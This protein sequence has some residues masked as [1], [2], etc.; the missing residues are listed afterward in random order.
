MKKMILILLSFNCSFAAF[1]Q[2]DCTQTTR[3]E[4]RELYCELQRGPNF[5]AEVAA[6]KDYCK[7]ESAIYKRVAD[8][9]SQKAD[10]L[11]RMG[12]DALNLRLLS[13]QYAVTS[14]RA[15]QATSSISLLELKDSMSSFSGEGACN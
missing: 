4:V 7:H 9:L 8:D 2:L 12:G 14:T 3:E 6:L 1:A 15:L 10:R 13:T 5:E 11:A